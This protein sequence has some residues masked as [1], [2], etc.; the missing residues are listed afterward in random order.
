MVFS[1][2]NI[3]IIGTPLGPFRKLTGSIESS[4]SYHSIT[5]CY[6]SIT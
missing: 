5:Q 6:Y 3:M 2:P 1:Y 4:Q